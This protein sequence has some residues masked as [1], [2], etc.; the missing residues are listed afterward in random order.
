M[1]WYLLF[2]LTAFADDLC[3]EGGASDSALGR[4]SIV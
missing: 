1:F 2:G 3:N 4:G